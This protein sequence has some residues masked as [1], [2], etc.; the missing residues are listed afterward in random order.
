MPLQSWLAAGVLV[1]AGSD[2]VRP[3]NPLLGVWGMVTRGTRDAGI[4][5][6]EQAIDRHVAIELL[7]TGG[8]AL[9]GELDRR[10]TLQPGRFADLVAYADDPFTAD[11][12]ELPRLEPVLTV[13][14]GRATHDPAGLLG[15]DRGGPLL[16]GAELE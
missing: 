9:I 2:T 5:G 3:V 1:S 8:A 6:S 13:V 4:V 16:G 7:T 15:G 12:D 11:I 14:G 10:G